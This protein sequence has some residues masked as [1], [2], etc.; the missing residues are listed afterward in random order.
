MS[1]NATIRLV[2][3][4]GQFHVR[5]DGTPEDVIATGVAGYGECP[6]AG[7][8]CQVEFQ[9]TRVFD[10]FAFD[11]FVGGVLPPDISGVPMPRGIAPGHYRIDPDTGKP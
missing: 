4:I 3:R 8:R 10:E 11:P 9:I 1:G 2:D 5:V 7:Q 6:R